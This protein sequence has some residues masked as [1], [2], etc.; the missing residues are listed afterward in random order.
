MEPLS[1]EETSL[2]RETIDKDSWKKEN[3]QMLKK[4]DL[5]KTCKSI[6]AAVTVLISLAVVCA[7]SGYVWGHWEYIKSFF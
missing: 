3:E 6:V 7:I 5:K 2:L 1:I 4:T